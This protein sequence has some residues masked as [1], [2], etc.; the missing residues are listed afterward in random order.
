MSHM[1][2]KKRRRPSRKSRATPP[3]SAFAARANLTRGGNH[4]VT[5]GL[6]VPHTRRRGGTGYV[7]RL[8]TIPTNWNGTFYLMPMSSKSD[9]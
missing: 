6:A 1:I 4:W 3:K 7:V 2:N 5:I 9:G 8:H